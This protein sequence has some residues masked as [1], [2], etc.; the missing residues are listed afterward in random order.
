MTGERTRRVISSV[1]ANRYRIVADVTILL[2]WIVFS[3]ALF[4]WL[5][6]PQWLH[7]LVSFG[8]VA[9]YARL[10]PSWDGR[11]SDRK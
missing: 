7:Y 10:T 6:L 1:R 11:S 5:E 4:G 2:A 3:T 8:G 9:V